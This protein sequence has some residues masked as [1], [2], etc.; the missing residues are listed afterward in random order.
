MPCRPWEESAQGPDQPNIVTPPKL[1]RND[2]AGHDDLDA[3][4]F[5][6]L[7]ISKKGQLFLAGT[8]LEY[9]EQLESEFQFKPIVAPYI[10]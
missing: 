10:L 4:R 1:P 9:L 7:V 8:R 5:P 2:G 3:S 6:C